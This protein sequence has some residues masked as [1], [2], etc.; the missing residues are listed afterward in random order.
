MEHRT[1]HERRHHPALL[2]NTYFGFNGKVHR[3]P[4]FDGGADTRDGERAT[5]A[6]LQMLHALLQA[7]RR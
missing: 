2:S 4:T 6:L 5:K 1:P 7:L 3:A